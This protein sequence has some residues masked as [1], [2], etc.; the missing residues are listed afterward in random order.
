MLNEPTFT[1]IS[2]VS[3]VSLCPLDSGCSLIS[4]ISIRPLDRS[5]PGSMVSSFNGTGFLGRINSLV[6]IL[7]F[8]EGIFKV[9][10]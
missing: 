5:G 7:Q 6:E 3:L 9:S 4:L 10:R 2:F 1:T 8:V